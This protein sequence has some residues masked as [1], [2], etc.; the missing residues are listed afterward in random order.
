MEPGRAA[1]NTPKGLDFETDRGD[2][3]Y[4]FREKDVEHASIKAVLFSRVN[5][6]GIKEVS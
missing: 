2:I 1:M 4:R 5:S 3:Q 6:I